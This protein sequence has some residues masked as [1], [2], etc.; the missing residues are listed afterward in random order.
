MNLWIR[1]SAIFLLKKHIRIFSHFL[2]E[3]TRS[4]VNEPKLE[5]QLNEFVGK[6]IDDLANTETPLGQMFTVEA[7]ELLKEKAVEQIDPIVRQ[8]AELATEDRTRTQ[9]STLI[10]KEVHDYYEALPFIKKIFVSRDN[11]LREVD[12]LVDE[13]LP[14]RIEETLQGDFFADE[15]AAFVNKNIDKVLARP[16][17][18]LIG[19]IEQEHL[20]SLKKQFTGSILSVLQSSEMQNSISAFLTDTLEK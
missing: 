20:D 17:P 16:L 13:S 15:A 19:T 7:I 11:L 6:R 18:E 3:K 12:E 5:E 9:I 14:K 10:K 8:L 4:I 1:P 2:E